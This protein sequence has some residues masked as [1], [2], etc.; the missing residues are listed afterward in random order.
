MS[1]WGYNG[2]KPKARVDCLLVRQRC[3][4]GH[5][6]LPESDLSV[7]NR[8]NSETQSY[9]LP[10]DTCQCSSTRQFPGGGINGR[11]VTDI[12][13]CHLFREESRRSLRNVW[14]I[15]IRGNNS[16]APGLSG[17]QT[18]LEFEGRERRFC[19]FHS[20]VNLFSL[21]AELRVPLCFDIFP[22][23]ALGVYFT[24]SVAALIN[25]LSTIVSPVWCP[26]SRC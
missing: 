8:N 3:T 19:S 9:Q 26:Y 14:W 15:L 11:Q 18:G 13:T 17:L 4:A 10:N 24:G 5:R 25:S 21:D 20:F 16:R 6:R 2:A 7:D 23:L 22:Q 1:F 12:Q